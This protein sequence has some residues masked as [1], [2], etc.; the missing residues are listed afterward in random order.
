MDRED[1]MRA[2][3]DEVVDKTQYYHSLRKVRAPKVLEDGLKAASVWLERH[4]QNSPA[5]SPTVETALR[6]NSPGSSE[7]QAV[8][9]RITTTNLQGAASY[10]PETQYL[11]AQNKY[12]SQSPEGGMSDS[13]NL[14]TS[15]IPSV[16]SSGPF[17][18]RL[19]IDWVCF[20]ASLSPI[21]RI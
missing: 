18:E 5:M 17:G 11:G 15:S 6:Q 21:F 16:A 2:I 9:T 20:V 3:F 1:K 13:S 8:Q 14:A 12:M 19:D 7:R 4:S 10:R